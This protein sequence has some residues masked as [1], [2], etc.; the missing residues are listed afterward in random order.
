LLADELYLAA[1]DDVSGKPRQAPSAIGLALG[2]ALLGELMLYGRVTLGE[3]GV[4]VVVKH[5]PPSDAL[6][7]TILD[8]LLGERQVHSP[9]ADMIPFM[10]NLG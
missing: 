6:A 7:H 10:I 8:S 9:Q 4:V 3:R 5:R 2:A 1:H